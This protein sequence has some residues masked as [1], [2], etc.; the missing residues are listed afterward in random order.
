[1]P[2]PKLELPFGGAWEWSGETTQ[3]GSGSDSGN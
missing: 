3:S 2:A 1:M